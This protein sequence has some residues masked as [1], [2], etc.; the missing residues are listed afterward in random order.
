MK[1]K[2][3]K[4]IIIS[5]MMAVFTAGCG[6]TGS[7]AEAGV[8]ETNMT[9]NS[10][11]ANNNASL[12]ASSEAVQTND[13]SSVL[14]EYDEDEAITIDLSDYSDIAEISEPGTY[15]I[16]GELSD[17]S[18]LIN[19]GEDDE[20]QLILRDVTI[21]SDDSAPIYIKSAS[22]VYITVEGENILEN[23][24]V[25]NPDEEEEIDGVIYSKNDLMIGG[26]GTLA[27]SSS[28]KGIVCNDSLE[29]SGGTYMIT[30]ADDGI[31]TNDMLTVSGGTFTIEAGDD[32]L[33]T[34]GYMGINGGTIDIIAAE[35]L[36]ATYIMI[37]NGDI[38]ITATDD[39]INAAAKSDD[40]TPTV[41]INGGNITI[42]MGQGDTDGIDSNGNIIING[43][44]IDISGQSAYDYDGYAEL[45][46]GTL[47]VNG[48]EITTIENQFGG[49]M[50]GGQMGE[51]PGGNGFEGNKPVGEVPG[52][53]MEGTG[54]AGG[55][56]PGGPGQ[57]EQEFM[58]PGSQ[59]DV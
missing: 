38:N 33:H 56:R 20:I 30:A 15:I 7:A 3:I 8:S 50:P 22:Q 55:M 23:T 37:N 10:E 26:S 57:S 43:G 52:E 19:G 40:Y 45:N 16:T 29:I 24:G 32:G 34:D 31:N 53:P 27:I 35:G 2:L 42:V 12:V 14:P 9:L 28:A 58:G 25:F 18:L 5:I 54:P 48:E 1:N 11:A 6:T 49:Q 59:D 51:F 47:T 17:G 41:E 21:T 46:G 44:T 4:M 13:E 39:G 36:E